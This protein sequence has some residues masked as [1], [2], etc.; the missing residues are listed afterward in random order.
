MLFSHHLH[1]VSFQDYEMRSN[2]YRSTL[3]DDGDDEE[4]DEDDETV[5][6]KR[7]TLTMA[8]AVQRKVRWWTSPYR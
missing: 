1:H 3:N 2:T 5:V 6:K 8:K 7:P 4:D